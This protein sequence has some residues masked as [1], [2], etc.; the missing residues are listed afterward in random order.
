MSV[1][2]PDGGLVPVTHVGT[3]R[4]NCG[5]TLNNVLVI[6]SFKFNLLSVSRL[7][8]HGLYTALFSSKSCVFQDNKSS[9]KI[10]TAELKD[11]LYW[12]QHNDPSSPDKASVSSCS[13][14][15]FL[16]MAF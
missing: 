3:V 5:L 2:L 16:S 10:G 14:S 9:R 4:F 8:E 13:T 1:R 6:P 11:G 15:F 12:F 7:V